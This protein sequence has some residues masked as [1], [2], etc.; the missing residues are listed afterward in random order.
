MNTDSDANSSTI[1][2]FAIVAAF[3]IPPLVFL[4]VGLTEGMEL[5]DILRALVDQYS[6]NR[7]NLAV[8][9]LV[10]VLPIALLGLVVWLAGKTKRIRTSRRRLAIGGVMAILAILIWSNFE[11][12]PT[13][14]PHR[15]YAGF[16][17]GLEFVVGPLI[18]APIAM[19]FGMVVAAFLPE[20]QQR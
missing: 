14:L 12:W 5:I 13:F 3:A 11:F 17:H 2:V 8:L 1:L 10:G 16:P 20:R 6:T 4:I 18:F 7:Q 9:G 19:I 15:T